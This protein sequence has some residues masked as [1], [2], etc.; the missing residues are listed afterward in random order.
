LIGA[1]V[2]PCARVA[3]VARTVQAELA[4]NLTALAV[5]T[6]HHQP[7]SGKPFCL[8][9]LSSSTTQWPILRRFAMTFSQ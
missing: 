4:F 3:R 7:P 1:E 5:V 9:Q 6:T 2:L 8:A